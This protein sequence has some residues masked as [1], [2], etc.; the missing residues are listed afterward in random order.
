MAVQNLSS[1]K[2]GIA[3]GLL[4]AFVALAAIGI[5][6]IYEQAWGLVFELAYIL[7]LLIVFLIIADQLFIR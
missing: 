5:W 3:G 2:T 1:Q 7:G 4:V 6:Y